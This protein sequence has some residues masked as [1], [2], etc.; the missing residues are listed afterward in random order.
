MYK[1]KNKEKIFLKQ[2]QLQIFHIANSGVHHFII[3][4]PLDVVKVVKLTLIR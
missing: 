4:S 3:T 2:N 1:N